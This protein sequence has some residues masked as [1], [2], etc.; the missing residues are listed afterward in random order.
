MFV[1]IEI[2]MVTLSSNNTGNSK[3]N[4]TI[5]RLNIVALQ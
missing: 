3:V 2:C 4:E 5:I 1:V